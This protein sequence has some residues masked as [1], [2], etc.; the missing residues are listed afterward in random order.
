MQIQIS[1]CLTDII[2]KIKRINDINNTQMSEVYPHNSIAFLVLLLI[3]FIDFNICEAT[4]NSLKLDPPKDPPIKKLSALNELKKLLKILEITTFLEGEIDP[5][6]K[7]KLTTRIVDHQ[8][9]ETTY[10]TPNFENIDGKFKFSQSFL[11]ED[12]LDKYVLSNS[13]KVDVIGT[14]NIG[15]HAQQFDSQS[16]EKNKM[17]F[18]KYAKYLKLYIDYL[19]KY[20]LDLDSNYLKDLER[21]FVYYGSLSN[22]ENPSLESSF[23]MTNLKNLGSRSRK[24]ETLSGSQGEED[25]SVSYGISNLNGNEDSHNFQNMISTSSG[26]APIS[27]LQLKAHENNEYIRGSIVGQAISKPNEGVSMT[28]ID[29]SGQ[30]EAFGFSDNSSYS[31]QINGSLSTVSEINNLSVASSKVDP[32]YRNMHE[33]YFV[34]RSKKDEKS[35]INTKDLSNRMGQLNPVAKNLINNEEKK[36]KRQIAD[37]VDSDPLY[38]K[39]GKKTIN[40]YCSKYYF[41]LQIT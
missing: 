30:N 31:E 11:Q 8:N 3:C 41:I 19:Y 1:Y 15:L 39:S 20:N 9:G 7:I 23:Q 25:S 36:N 17:M 29:T 38:P 13:S 4:L 37:F 6:D 35:E 33:N 32:Q 27:G 18:K 40:E 10:L 22:G 34:D 26:A 12:S 14:G 24:Y 2:S 28:T 21:S 5:D 16:E